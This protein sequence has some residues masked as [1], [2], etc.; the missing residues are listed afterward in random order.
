MLQKNTQIEGQIISAGELVVKSQYICSVQENTN[1]YWKQ[2]SLQHNII[3]TTCTIL[4]P[5]LDVIIITDVQDIPN[6]VCNSNQAKKAI[7]RH[8]I[9][10]ADSDYDYI[11]DEIEN[12]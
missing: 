1:W 11:L 6:T 9:C 4:H 7:Q 10:M 8:L 5:C 12:R 3:V 2:Q